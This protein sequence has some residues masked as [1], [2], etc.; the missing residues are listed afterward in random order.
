VTVMHITTLSALNIVIAVMFSPVCTAN[1]NRSYI[2]K[3]DTAI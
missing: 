2:L 1:N 3:K